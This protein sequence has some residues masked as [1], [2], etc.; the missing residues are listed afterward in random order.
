MRTQETR[1]SLKCDILNYVRQFT[2]DRK[3]WK[4]ALD[5]VKAAAFETP[6]TVCAEMLAANPQ[7]FGD[8]DCPF[9]EGD[10]VVCSLTLNFSPR[11]YSTLIAFVQRYEAIC[12][13]EWEADDAQQQEKD[14]FLDRQRRIVFEGGYD[15]DC[16]P[17]EIVISANHIEVSAIGYRGDF[18]SM[19]PRGGKYQGRGTGTWRYPRSFK[20]RFEQFGGMFN[21]MPVLYAVESECPYFSSKN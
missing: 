12:E 20:E 15:H 5:V 7:F 9:S 11:H 21:G 14:D 4:K 6:V 19:L 13:A 18:K 10:E 3:A 16:Y 17:G 1:E 8:A 2:A